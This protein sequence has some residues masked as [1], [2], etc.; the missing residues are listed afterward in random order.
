MKPPAWISPLFYLSALYD[1]VL[2]F[3]F[4][5][6]PLYIFDAFDVTPPNHVGYVQFPA[7]LLLIFGLIF[8][9]IARDPRA[10]RPLI[11]YGVMLKVAYCGVTA[12]HWIAT[13]IPWIWKPFVIIDL[14][15]LILF[16]CAYAALRSPAETEQPSALD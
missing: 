4:L 5:A 11:L 10:N 15:M 2:G 1:G 3:L 8:L 12:S 13:G 14:L 6:A 9:Q 7:A 16:I